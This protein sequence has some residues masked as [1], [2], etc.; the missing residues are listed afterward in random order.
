M[1][2]QVLFMISFFISL[3][4]ARKKYNQA[5]TNNP[6]KKISNF[7]SSIPSFLL[8]FVVTV[9]IPLLVMLS[10]FEPSQETTIESPE[11]I[12][13]TEFV[14][15][16]GEPQKYEI[17]KREDKSKR[18]TNRVTS[19]W[20]SS[21]D[22]VDLSSRAATVK[23]AA[24]DLQQKINVPIVLVYLTI[25]KEGMG[26]GYNLAIARYFSDGCKYSGDECDDVIWSV[27]ATSE[28]IT[29]E[30]IR[31]LSEWYNNR[32]MFL[33]KENNLNEEKLIS[34][35]SK[36][37]KIPTSE[38]LLPY[39]T[40]EKVNPYISEE[41]EK[42]SISRMKQKQKA[43]EKRKEE[44][45]LQFSHWDG[46]HRD[47]ERR[48]KESMND[49]DSYKHYKTFY[50]DHGKHI[51]VITGF[52]GRNSFGGMVRNTISADYTINGDFIKIN[53]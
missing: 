37:L 50:L 38:I 5:N 34:F 44:I 40:T 16:I 33:D 51:T 19:F 31:I 17:L 41:D 25:N 2:Y 13:K 32:K 15:Q 47:L 23:K 52:G 8:S 26:M 6:N 14:R 10:Y 11:P 3:F 20:I 4:F 48:I 21:P 30:Q 53:K 39:F 49:P 9:I 29:P 12:K 36:K 28:V 35:L 45:E 43:A 18:D 24:E 1:K 7:I 27:E 46:S 42:D 22:A